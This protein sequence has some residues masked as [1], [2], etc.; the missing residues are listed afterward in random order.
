MTGVYSRV[1]DWSTNALTVV[2][3]LG[4]IALAAIASGITLLLR[5]PSP[6]PYLYFLGGREPT[7]WGN[8]PRR[9]VRLALRA[10]AAAR[11]Q[12]ATAEHQRPRRTLQAGAADA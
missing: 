2:L 7:P 8:H 1:P 5:R 6:S 10:G 12:R 11:I 4:G 9:R 3:V